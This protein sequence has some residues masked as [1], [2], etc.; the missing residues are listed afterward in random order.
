VR[1]GMERWRKMI[2]DLLE[3]A[4]RQYAMES[5]ISLET[6][7]DMFTAIIEGGIMLARNFD[8]NRLLVN[9]IMGYRAFLRLLYGAS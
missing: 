7:A 2:V 9:Q 1:L 5:E 4:N 3:Q 6:L 8:D